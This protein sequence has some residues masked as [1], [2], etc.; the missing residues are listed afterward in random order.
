MK[1]HGRTRTEIPLKQG[2]SIAQITMALSRPAMTAT[3]EINSFRIQAN[4]TSLDSPAQENNKHASDI[5]SNINRFEPTHSIILHY[6]RR[7]TLE[8][9]STVRNFRTEFSFMV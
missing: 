5:P 9:L 6:A 2:F 4:G 1:R 7:T 3:S 8:D